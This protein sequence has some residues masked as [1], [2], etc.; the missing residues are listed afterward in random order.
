MEESTETRRHGQESITEVTGKCG[1]SEN[2]GSMGVGRRVCAERVQRSVN[3]SQGALRFVFKQDSHVTDAWPSS[4]SRRSRKLLNGYPSFE[5][6]DARIQFLQNLLQTLPYS[7]PLLSL[8]LEVPVSATPPL[9]L[10]HHLAAYDRSTNQSSLTKMHKPRNS[11][12]RVLISNVTATLPVLPPLTLLPS[13]R[14][15]LR[16]MDTLLS[17]L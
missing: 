1:R 11:H 10:H 17:R 7:F 13:S 6:F 4:S 2:G 9:L 16:T 8:P 3:G 15:P 12:S 14:P 5:Q